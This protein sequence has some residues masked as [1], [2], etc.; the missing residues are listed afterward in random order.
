MKTSPK[1]PHIAHIGFMTP[2]D[3]AEKSGKSLQWIRINI[4]SGKLAATSIGGRYFIAP[5]EYRRWNNNQKPVGRPRK[6]ESGES[7]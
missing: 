7:E 3:I 5:E 1:D 4:R 6:A 2:A